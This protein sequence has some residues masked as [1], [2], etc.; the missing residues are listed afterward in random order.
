MFPCI[1]RDVISNVYRA[2]ASSTTPV[3]SEANTGSSSAPEELADARSS[4]LGCIHTLIDSYLYSPAFRTD[5][6]QYTMGP[7][8][9]SASDTPEYL[10]LSDEEHWVL[11]M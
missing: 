1:F 4:L 10:S 7:Q 5:D 3:D 6:Q 2:R 8:P 9:Q 11:A